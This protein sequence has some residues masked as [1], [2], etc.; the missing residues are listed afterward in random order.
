MRVVAAPW[1]LIT[2]REQRLR[3]SGSTRARL[4]FEADDTILYYGRMRLASILRPVGYASGL[5]AAV[6]M[7]A[8]GGGDQAD[9]KAAESGSSGAATTMTTA[10]SGGATSSDPK[11]YSSGSGAWA[12]FIERVKQTSCTDDCGLGCS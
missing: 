4:G 10:S 11:A 5:G 6:A 1:D 8:C 3:D 12:L 2:D 7:A 9:T